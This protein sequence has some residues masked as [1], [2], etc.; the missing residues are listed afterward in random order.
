MVSFPPKAAPKERNIATKAAIL[1]VF[2]DKILLIMR[3]KLI[4]VKYHFS[5][6]SSCEGK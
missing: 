1:T 4:V 5:I 3:F 2:L 6:T